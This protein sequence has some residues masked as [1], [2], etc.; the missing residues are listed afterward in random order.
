MKGHLMREAT[1]STLTP[2]QILRLP[3][4]INVMIDRANIWNV[5]YNARSD[6][7]H[8]ATSPKFCACHPKWHSQI[9]EKF[10]ENGWSV[11][12]NAR[13]IRPWS[14]N[15]P[16]MIRPW[17]RKPQ[18]APPRR[19]LFALAR[20]RFY[21]KLQHFPL[22]LSFQLS[23]NAC[24]ENWHMNFTKCCTCHKKV[25]HEFHQMLYP[26]QKVTRELHQ[27][28]RLPQS[29]TWTSPNVAPATKSVNFTKCCPCHEKWHMNFTKCCTC[30]KKWHMNLTKCCACHKKWQINF[31]QC[32][33][34]HKKWHM[35]FTKCC[36]C[37]KEVRLLLLL[38]L[39][40]LL[41]LL[42]RRRLLYYYYY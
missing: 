24:H 36:T 30:H 42:R 29:A 22:R 16:S 31:T 4:K 20:S 12:S 19:L 33:T 17:K 11:I 9:L 39:R 18:P 3:R 27:M 26:P 28:L 15:D 10:A 7:H 13:T 8:P 21:W 14:E 34:C 6:R 1:G 23:P 37:H 32:C 2:H 35:N 5:I 38:L 25:T 40:V 41:L